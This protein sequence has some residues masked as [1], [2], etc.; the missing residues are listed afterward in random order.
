MPY[1]LFNFLK[2]KSDPP[3]AQLGQCDGCFTSSGRRKV[4]SVRSGVGF[5]APRGLGHAGEVAPSP[6]AHPSAKGWLN[7]AVVHPRVILQY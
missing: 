2:I 7:A 5:P 3:A 1:M 6:S 4:I